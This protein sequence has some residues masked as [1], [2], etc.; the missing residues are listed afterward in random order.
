MSGTFTDALG[1]T[2]ENLGPG[3][4]FCETCKRTH[5]DYEWRHELSGPLDR[6]GFLLA[7]VATLRRVC[8]RVAG[9]AA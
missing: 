7:S 6:D 4:T 9:I 8:P 5:L 3:S 2:V 1:R